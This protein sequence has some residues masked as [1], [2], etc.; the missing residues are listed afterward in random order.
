[1][2]NMFQHHWSSITRAEQR[3]MGLKF[4]GK[5]FIARTFVSL[6]LKFLSFNHIIPSAFQTLPGTYMPSRATSH[7]SSPFHIKISQKCSPERPLQLNYYSNTKALQ[8]SFTP[9]ACVCILSHFTQVQLFK[10]N[11]MNTEFHQ[12]YQNQKTLL[13]AHLTQPLCIESR[14]LLFPVRNTFLCRHP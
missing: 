14:Q 7:I 1:M 11:S 13:Y 4:R 8:S 3:R 5:R 12:D 6:H 9:L 2:R 10:N